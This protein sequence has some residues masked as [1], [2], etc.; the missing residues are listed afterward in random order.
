MVR[1]LSPGRQRHTWWQLAGLDHPPDFC[2]SAWIEVDV[3]LADRRLLGQHPR[4]EQRLADV[5]G[6]RA[7][8]AGEAAGQ[9]RE[10]GVVAAPLA[11]PV[12]PLE[13]AARDAAAG[14]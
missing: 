13:D 11:H 5:A 2:C 4:R 9:V 7:V 1:I 14:V 6:E 12:E 8:V 3:P 10:L